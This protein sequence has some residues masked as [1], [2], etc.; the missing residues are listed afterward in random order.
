MFN[1]FLSWQTVPV[2]LYERRLFNKHLWFLYDELRLIFPA[3]KHMKGSAGVW[4][5]NVNIQGGATGEEGETGSMYT[6]APFTPPHPA[7]C[8]STLLLRTALKTL[9]G[10]CRLFLVSVSV[11]GL[12]LYLPPSPVPLSLC[13]LSLWIFA[14]LSVLLVCLCVCLSF[15]PLHF[16]YRLWCL[17]AL[18]PDLEEHFSFFFCLSSLILPTVFFVSIATY[19]WWPHLKIF[20]TGTQES[21]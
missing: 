3:S 4:K 5:H 17:P 6:P 19:F 10:G 18:R 21:F 1:F 12:S 16:L 8:P 13:P 20:S 9:S 2:K 15:Y 7:A 11:L 14:V